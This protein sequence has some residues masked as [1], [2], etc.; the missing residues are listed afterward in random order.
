MRDAV[1]TITLDRGSA[2]QIDPHAIV[3]GLRDAGAE[4]TDLPP[5]CFQ[6]EGTIVV[7]FTF[8]P[9]NGHSAEH[10]AAQIARQAMADLNHYRLSVH[11]DLASS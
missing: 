8:D 7:S 2:R 3:T 4:H 10:R 11:V 9:H 5:T 6:H 1:V